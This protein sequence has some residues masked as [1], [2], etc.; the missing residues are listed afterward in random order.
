MSAVDLAIPFC[1][2]YGLQTKSTWP[3]LD[4]YS[5][6]LC[7]MGNLNKMGVKQNDMKL[8]KL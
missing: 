8:L 1:T 6:K 3:I 4:R 7:L 5:T 2:S